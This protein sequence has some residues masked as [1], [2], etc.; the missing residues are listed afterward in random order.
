MRSQILSGC[1]SDT[2]SLVN[3]KSRFCKT[4]SSVVSQ[5]RSPALRLSNLGRR[6]SSANLRDAGMTRLGLG[7]GIG[8]QRLCQVEQTAA[9]RDVPDAVIGADQLHGLAPA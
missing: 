5:V 7:P 8:R 6:P 4:R 2:D 9:H 3:T 1:P